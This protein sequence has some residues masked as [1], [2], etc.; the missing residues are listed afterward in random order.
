MKFLSIQGTWPVLQGSGWSRSCRRRTDS[1]SVWHSQ[2]GVLWGKVTKQKLCRSG[3]KF[4]VQ[5]KPKSWAGLESV[6]SN[7][8]QDNKQLQNTKYSNSYNNNYNNKYKGT[9]AGR[10]R[11]RQRQGQR[12]RQQTFA[13]LSVAVS[14]LL[15][16]FLC[17][18]HCI[19]PC[20][21]V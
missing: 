13:V 16:L 19:L 21:G 6:A 1:Q 20:E 11:Q 9:S 4:I 17:L 3:K 5:F 2:S 18:S 14:L 8:E 15:S 10:D 12:G 7:N